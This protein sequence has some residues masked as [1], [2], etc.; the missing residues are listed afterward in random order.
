MDRYCAGNN[1]QFIVTLLVRLTMTTLITTIAIIVATTYVAGLPIP[2]SSYIQPPSNRETAKNEH[3]FLDWL[4][5]LR[6]RERL[7]VHSE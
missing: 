4:H 3:H 5:P 6:A 7:Q 1:L 2:C